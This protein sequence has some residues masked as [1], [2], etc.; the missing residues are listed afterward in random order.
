MAEKVK[1]T[2]VSGAPESDYDFLREN[3]DLNSF[4]IAAD[5]GYKKLEAIGITPDL[6]VADFDSCR[7]PETETEI[8]DY[9]VRK[10]AT[11]TFNAVK[12]ATDKGYKNIL[13]LGALGGRLDHSYSNIL[14]LDYAMKHGACCTIADR[15]HR[16]S[17]IRERAVI[18][19][20]YQW[21][22]LFAFLD[23]AKG[24]RIKGAGYEAGFYG[25]ESLD[26]KPYDQFGQSNY[27]KDE[28]CEITA[29]SGTLLL[30]EANDFR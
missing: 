27:V 11:D 3:T 20:S 14:C 5:S 4:I 15:N 13:L 10:D 24:I 12:I 16:I 9:P 8:I 2:I 23:D 29:E 22:S 17:L 21:F 25:K 28:Y 1:C 7:R 30:I 6:I 26:M 18:D 19:K